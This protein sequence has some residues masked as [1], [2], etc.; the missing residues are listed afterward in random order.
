[1]PS[2]LP[3]L[4]SSPAAG[5]RVRAWA[6]S[7]R[8]GGLALVLLCLIVYLPGLTSIPPVDRD[9]CRFAQAS[10]QMFESAT[11]PA[12]R[13]DVRTDAHARPLGQHAGGW[14]VPMVQDRPRLNKPPL[15][16]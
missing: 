5:T 12:E 16:Y 7:W 3:N 8:T 1:M 15:V 4:Y 14:V 11:L 9:E 13:Q 2:V 6:S 10:R